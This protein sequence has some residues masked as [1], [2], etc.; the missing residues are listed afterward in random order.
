VDPVEL[1][2]PGAGLVIDDFTPMTGWPPEFAGKVDADRM[3]W[4]EDQRL[5]TTEV[6]LTAEAASLVAIRR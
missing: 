3:H 6:R 4:L 5:L 1:L 2:K